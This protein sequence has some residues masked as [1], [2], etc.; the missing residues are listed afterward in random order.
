MVKKA[1]FLKIR[2]GQGFYLP[3]LIFIMLQ[4][5]WCNNENC[6]KDLKGKIK[7][8]HYSELRWMY[9]LKIPQKIYK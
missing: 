4:G 5:R 9:I 2:T 6:K 7:R 1:F 8:H 3:P